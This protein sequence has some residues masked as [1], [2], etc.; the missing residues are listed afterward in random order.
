MRRFLAQMKN[1]TCDGIPVS[2]LYNCIDANFEICSG[3]GVCMHNACVCDRG[4]SGHYCEWFLTDPPSS[5]DSIAPQLAGTHRLAHA[6]GCTRRDVCG[7]ACGCVCAVD[8]DPIDAQV[9]RWR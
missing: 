9:G 7:G 6:C 3:A 4:R 5:S 8:G 1:L 2:D